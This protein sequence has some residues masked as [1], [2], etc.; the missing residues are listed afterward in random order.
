MDKNY[1]LRSK[2]YDVLVFFLTDMY[3]DAFE[4]VGSL[5][6]LSIYTLEDV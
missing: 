2:I 6:L 4:C 1:S 5:I 3:L